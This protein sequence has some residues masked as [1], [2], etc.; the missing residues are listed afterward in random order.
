LREFFQSLTGWW[1]YVFLFISSVG[2]NLFPPMPGDTFVVLGAFL[3]GRGQMQ[4]IPAYLSTTAGS[5]IGFMTLY[6]VG[7]RWGRRLFRGKL[8]TVFSKER[9]DKV[10]TWF[11]R[12][13]YTVLAVNRF[14]SGF[15]SIISLGA[16][17]SR[18][19]W[20]IVF[21][22]ALLS[23][24]LW[25]GLLMVVGMWIGENWIQIVRHYQKIVFFL[26]VFFIFVVWIKMILKKRKG[27]KTDCI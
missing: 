12:Y 8:G 2:E 14:L 22:M 16:G 24:V 17:I 25:N 10:E 6:T 23:C 7:F 5:I 9:L 11:G 27:R 1:G 21:G 15:R 20:K 19:N 18:M 26:L 4:F 3:V 13:G